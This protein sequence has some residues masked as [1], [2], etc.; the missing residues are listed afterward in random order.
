MVGMVAAALRRR[1][2]LIMMSF[3]VMEIP[4]P[5]RST[6]VGFSLTSVPQRSVAAAVAGA[7][8]A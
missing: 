1:L 5:C 2:H 4:P 3:L 7:L 6:P 8:T